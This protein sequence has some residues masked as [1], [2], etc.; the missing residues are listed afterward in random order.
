MPKGYWVT[1]YRSISDPKKRGAASRPA[2]LVKRRGL[3]ADIF[4]RLVDREELAH[5]GFSPVLCDFQSSGHAIVLNPTESR[6]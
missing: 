1:T 2:V 4:G 6:L 5:A 3:E